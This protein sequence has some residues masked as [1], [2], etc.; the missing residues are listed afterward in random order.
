MKNSLPLWAVL[1]ILFLY[2]LLFGSTSLI[3]YTNDPK[4]LS[5]T[6]IVYGIIGFFSTTLLLFSQFLEGPV[7]ITVDGRPNDD[8]LHLSISINNKSS[9]TIEIN[10][11]VVIGYYSTSAHEEEGVNNEIF[12]K[13]KIESEKSK[14]FSYPMKN[15]EKV[16]TKRTILLKKVPVEIR[17]ILIDKGKNKS[18]TKYVK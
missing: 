18:I 12:E 4:S 14:E 5:Q 9:S 17:Y 15:A 2:L 13:I 3:F 11:I 8:D 1:S 16:K 10:E 6:A 7:K